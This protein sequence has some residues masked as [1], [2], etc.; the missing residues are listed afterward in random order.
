MNKNFEDS[1]NPHDYDKEAQFAKEFLKKFNSSGYKG[2]YRELGKK[3]Y[4]Q[5]I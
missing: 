1:I 5:E 3:K 4:L 2:P